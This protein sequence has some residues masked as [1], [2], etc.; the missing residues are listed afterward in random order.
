MT[1]LPSS[2]DSGA[3]GFDRLVGGGLAADELDERHDRHGTEEMHADE[4]GTAVRLDR[5]GQPMDRDRARVRGEDRVRRRVAVE[6]PPQLGLDR[7]VLED[8]FD[9]EV[10]TRDG[11]GVGG[12]LDPGQRR[13]ALVRREAALVHGALEV[14]PRCVPCPAS[15]RARSGSYSTTCLPMAA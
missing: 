8:G 2:A 10:G 11:V 7:H 13:L 3:H 4:P 14:R 12:R 5:L 9:G 6:H 1:C 15:A